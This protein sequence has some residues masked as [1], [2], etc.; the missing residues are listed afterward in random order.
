MPSKKIALEK[1]YK[2][3]KENRK[4]GK[5]KEIDIYRDRLQL[6]IK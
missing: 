6:T 1:F 5:I 2:E 4:G 3:D